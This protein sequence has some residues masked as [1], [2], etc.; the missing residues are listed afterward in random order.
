M[1]FKAGQRV[2]YWDSGNHPLVKETRLNGR[3]AIV[4]EYT[5]VNNVYIRW[6]SPEFHYT[7]ARYD[8]GVYP[9][10]LIPIGEQ[11][12]LPFGAENV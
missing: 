3:E 11:M 10:N 8:Y 6:T 9:D 2:V 7:M 5:S 4:V 1:K 12:M